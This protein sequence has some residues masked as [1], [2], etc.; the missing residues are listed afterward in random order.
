M[1]AAEVLHAISSPP[2]ECA[3]EVG[4]YGFKG[5]VEA[6]VQG[7]VS[8]TIVNEV[9]GGVLVTKASGVRTIWGSLFA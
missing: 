8:L 7:G 4:S 6:V 3:V 1:V 2:P 5:F 9:V